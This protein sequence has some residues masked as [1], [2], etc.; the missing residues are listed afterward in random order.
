MKKALMNSSVAS[1]IYKFNMD[2][3]DA[4]ETLGYKIDVACNF[5]R[6]N[7]ISEKEIADFKNILTEKN[8]RFFDT[9]CPRSVFAL[10]NMFTA[11]K[12]LKKIADGGHYDLVHTQSPIGGVVCRLAF[13]K[14]RKNGT[15]VI[16]QAHGFH[17][18]KG[19]PFLNWLIFYPI[20]KLCSR[21]T[22]ILITINKEDYALAKKK[23]HARKTEYVPGIGLDTLRFNNCDKRQKRAE[24]NIGEDETLLL[25][26][27]ELNDNK[28]HETV[29]KALAQLKAEMPVDGIKYLI[30]GQ[31]EKMNALKQLADSLGLGDTVRFLGFRTDVGEIYSAADAF[32]FPSYREGLPVSLMEAMASGL[33]CAVSRIR[34]NT[35]LI[36][37][38]GGML[39]NPHSADDCKMALKDI[40]KCD[41]K[42]FGEYNTKKIKAF[43]ILSVHEK[44]KKIYKEI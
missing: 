42:K 5:G 20:E 7:P 27:G 28:N 16:Y 25:S 41:L 37:E 4:L 18:Y 11:Y 26:V 13:R 44:M 43:S 14:A 23:F 29:I 2:N 36:D 35:D 22:D 31:G 8:I 24:L 39:F 34:G 30:C 19:A 15:K 10:K 32:V 12:Q 21:F 1:M 6:E 40:L 17:F 33:P 3:I 38:N 9:T